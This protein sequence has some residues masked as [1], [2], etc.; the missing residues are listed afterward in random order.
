MAGSDSVSDGPEAPA[1]AGPWSRRDLIQIIVLLSVVAG[2]TA[3][4]QFTPLG[5]RLDPQRLAD[6]AAPWRDDPAALLYVVGVHAILGLLG[7]PITML[8]L[9]TVL[10]FGAP[11]GMA[12]SWV[13]GL[14]NAT[15]GYVLGLVITR[16]TLLEHLDRSGAVRRIL[17]RHG[18]LSVI[19]L[20]NLP[21]GPFIV[22]NVLSGA[23]R[24]RYTDY[25]LGTAIGIIPPLLV[26][27][28]G[29]QRFLNALQHP[30]PKSLAAL[31]ATI[32]IV[33][34]ALAWLRHRLRHVAETAPPP[35]P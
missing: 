9:A 30:G 34:L 27:T 6:W 33:V 7:F 16:P 24:V 21:I 23:T 13:G 25:I 17:A 31:A 22:V 20:R 19:V 26:V 29:A 11:L 5:D 4:W 2:L 12:Y 3:L 8:V 1:P 15:S 28:L 18:V 32:I 35:T 10:V 14:A